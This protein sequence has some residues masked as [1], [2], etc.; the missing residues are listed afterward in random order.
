M[1]DNVKFADIEQGKGGL[2][3]HVCSGVSRVM[4]PTCR[5]KGEAIKY[6]TPHLAGTW[7]VII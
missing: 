1:A 2:R 5:L 4:R 6:T 3:E 7:L